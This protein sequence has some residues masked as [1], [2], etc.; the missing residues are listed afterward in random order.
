M[1][2]IPR[3]DFLRTILLASVMICSSLSKL[4]LADTIKIGG[5]GSAISTMRILIEAFEKSNPN[6]NVIIVPGLGSGGARKAVLA[7]AIDLGVT[8]RAGKAAEK[9]EGAVA[10]EYGRTPL[11]FATSKKNSVS[12]LTAQEV[13]DIYNGKIITWPNGERLRL[14]LR[15]A[16]DSDTAVLKSISPAMEQAVKHALSRQ[17]IKIAV[18]DHDSA[19]AIETVPGALGTSTLAIVISEGRSVKTLSFNGV[20]PSTKTVADGSYPLFKSFYLLTGPKPSKLTQGFIAFVRSSEG[21][22]ILTQLGHW[23]VEAKASE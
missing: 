10:I 3:R 2:P 23:V 4:V 8:G 18:T 5:T 7:A 19:D 21:R 1:S 9:L 22:K 16:S 6:V 20:E 17:G 13:V 14:I 11:I 12:G 15:P